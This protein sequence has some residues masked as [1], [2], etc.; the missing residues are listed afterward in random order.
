MKIGDALGKITGL[1]ATLALVA[2]GPTP[3][4]Y[5]ELIPV[6][7]PSVGKRNLIV[8]VK[9]WNDERK[10]KEALMR[11]MLLLIPLFPYSVDEIETVKGRDQW[12]N[13]QMS[14]YASG[15]TQGFKDGV[16]G[17]LPLLCKYLRDSKLA[18]HV[19]FNGKVYGGEDV[20]EPDDRNPDSPEPDIIIESTLS[21]YNNWMSM[22][23]YGLS[24]FTA[25]SFFLASGSQNGLEAEFSMT[26]KD[27]AGK[28]ISQ[29]AI[30]LDERTGFRP[31]FGAFSANAAKWGQNHHLIA[32]RVHDELR[33]FVEDI[34]KTLPPET[35][36]H[37]W[38]QVK[39]DRMKRIAKSK[40]EKIGPAITLVF[41]LTTPFRTRE[42]KVDLEIEAEGLY[43]PIR[44]V[45]I[46]K[47]QD[48]IAREERKDE[49]EGLQKKA[50]K[51][52]VAL[53]SGTNA[54][55][56]E[57]TD[58]E[59]N[60]SKSTVIVDRFVD[61]ATILSSGLTAAAAPTTKIDAPR[62]PESAGVLPTETFISVGKSNR[63][64][65]LLICC[66]DYGNGQFETLRT[67]PNDIRKL[68]DV[69]QS[70]YGFDVTLLDSAEATFK[71]IRAALKNL[72][73]TCK[74]EDNVLI[75]YAGHGFEDGA[76]RAGYWLPT[77]ARD[78][79]EGLA[80]VEI[81][82]RI[83]R[84]PARRVL[85]VSDS[86]FSGE[87]LTRR[88]ISAGTAPFIQDSSKS[89]EVSVD[90]A[91]NLNPSRE[92]ITSGNREPVQDAGVGYCADHSPFACALIT[93]L[94]KVPLG[95]AL[96][97]TD[98]YVDVYGSLR[99]NPAY[100]QKPQRGTIEGHNGGEFFLVHFKGND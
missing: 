17:I 73:E 14:L 39:R 36:T 44:N 32:Q 28:I 81:K 75:Y 30:I 23:F 68:R 54:I 16:H 53:D 69:L 61:P 25:Y 45:V 70:Q 76:S 2:C 42:E 37:Y 71:G 52:T 72:Q 63:W 47:F 24:F 84:L 78:T 87:F 21:R 50:V 5:S 38:S 82:D 93:A 67:P 10:G 34:S 40:D 83:A 6:S 85:L 43:I 91:R 9:P 31:F 94:E 97:S 95:A 65:A 4:T 90:L 15:I 99:S 51:T 62:K 13:P 77:D 46:K 66:S 98:L 8:D 79:N 96:S 55:T 26:A 58:V 92:I 19:Y 33:A 48:E 80:N 49:E 88:N 64:K 18:E 29:R 1:A 60:V 74:P 56:I 20:L 22:T 11:N 86:C 12:T 7:P 100:V 59:G 3:R 27:A 35:D 89:V 57:A 41:P